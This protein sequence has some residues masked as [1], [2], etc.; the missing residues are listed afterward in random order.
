LRKS[1]VRFRVAMGRGRKM[2]EAEAGRRE[3][4]ARSRRRGGS[5][6]ELRQLGREERRVRAALGDTSPARKEGRRRAADDRA[7]VGPGRWK[8]EFAFG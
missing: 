8:K 1:G 2:E 6:E 4:A 3:R 5:G 7:K